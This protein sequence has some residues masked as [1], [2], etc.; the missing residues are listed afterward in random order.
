MTD[1]PLDSAADRNPS[2]AATVDF[3]ASSADVDLGTGLTLVARP[4]SDALRRDLQSA[5]PHPR[6]RHTA[7]VR[8]DVVESDQALRADSQLPVASI[9]LQVVD[10]SPAPEVLGIATFGEI[11]LPDGTC[12][13]IAQ[14]IGTKLRES[15][16]GRASIVTDWPMLSDAFAKQGYTKSNETYGHVTVSRDL[17]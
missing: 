3:L 2:V 13:A 14:A 11:A 4:I 12:R 6:A 1:S 16:A 15:S 7:S 5:V 8:F 10:Q 17:D 9:T